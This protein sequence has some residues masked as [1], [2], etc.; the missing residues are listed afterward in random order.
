M[1]TYCEAVVTNLTADVGTWVAR[2]YDPNPEY[3]KT[4][5]GE[6]QPGVPSY[7]ITEASGE[8]VVK[9]LDAKEARLKALT[10]A[11]AAAQQLMGE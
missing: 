3:D 5:A 4:K 1:K 2:R 7:K 9:G 10:D 6:D 11:K 8:T